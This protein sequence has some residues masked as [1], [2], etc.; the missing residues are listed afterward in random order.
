MFELLLVTVIVTIC[1]CI[2]TLRIGMEKALNNVI[3]ASRLVKSSTNEDHTAEYKSLMNHISNMVLITN[4]AFASA[5]LYGI[6]LVTG[7]AGLYVNYYMIGVLVIIA[8]NLIVALYYH[9]NIRM[10]TKATASIVQYRTEMNRSSSGQFVSS[11]SH[12]ED[13]LTSSGENKNDQG[14]PDQTTEEKGHDN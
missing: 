12:K 13:N 11:T 6:A 7:F 1:I 14:S 8:L 3:Q 5:V 10:L 4:G 9:S 2:Y